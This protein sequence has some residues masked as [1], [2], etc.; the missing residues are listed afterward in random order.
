MWYREGEDVDGFRGPIFRFLSEDPMVLP[1]FLKEVVWGGSGGGLPRAVSVYSP[2][3]VG[4]D[5]P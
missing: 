4:R 3:A 5:A 2:A 1:R